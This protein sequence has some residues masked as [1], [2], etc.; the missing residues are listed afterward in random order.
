MPNQQEAVENVAKQV[1]V[2]LEAA[3]LSA[4]SDLLDPNVHWGAPDDPSPSCQNRK[5]VLAWYQRGR[6]AGIRANVTEVE[7]LGDRILVGLQVAGNQATDERGDISERWQVL[8][9]RDGRVVDIVGFDDR[10]E[11]EARAGSRRNSAQPRVGRDGSTLKPQGVGATSPT[12]RAEG[13]GRE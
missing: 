13:E 9:V 8:T 11:A 2:A 6:D 4:F 12:Q 7:I 10:Y 5:Q 1:R 3:D